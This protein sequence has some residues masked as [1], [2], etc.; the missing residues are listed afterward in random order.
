MINI[1][2]PALS[3]PQLKKTKTKKQGKGNV[4]YCQKQIWKLSKNIYVDESVRPKN[5]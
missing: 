4:I 5:L 1:E 3:H 2:D